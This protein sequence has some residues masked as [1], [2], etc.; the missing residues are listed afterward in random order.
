M[1]VFLFKPPPLS[2]KDNKFFVLGKTNFSYGEG[3]KF[4]S[5]AP[6]SIPREQVTNAR[7][8]R[9]QITG[10]KQDKPF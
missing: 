5:P 10:L 4:F 2:F 3:P 6:L 1:E 8:Y 9:Y 7:K